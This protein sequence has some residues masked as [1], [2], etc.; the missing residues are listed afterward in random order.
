LIDILVGAFGDLVLIDANLNCLS[1]SVETGSCRKV[2]WILILDF[3]S[4]TTVF[5]MVDCFHDE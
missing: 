5:D 3:I 1:R 4:I 2:A